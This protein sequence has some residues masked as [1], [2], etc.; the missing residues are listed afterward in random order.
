VG[1]G[2]A[3]VWKYKSTPGAPDDS[4][5]MAWPAASR[6]ER[7][8]D[9]PVLLLFAHP[10]CPCTRASVR[11]LARLMARVRDRVD[12]HVLALRPTDVGEEWDGAWLWSAAA[13]IPGV[14]VTADADGREAARFHAATSGQTLLYDARGRLAFSGGLTASRGHE[15]DSFG[16]RRIVALLTTGAADRPDSPVFGCAL[17][18]RDRGAAPAV[19][20]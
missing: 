17:F 6:I 11:E 7:Q 20:E 18:A 10:Q 5:P 3:A 4:P 1:A 2:F 16:Q 9:R 8:P 12:A 13:E 15:G 14:T 19:S